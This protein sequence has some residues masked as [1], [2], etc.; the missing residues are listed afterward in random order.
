[1]RFKRGDLVGMAIAT[2]APVA[3]FLLVLAA[4]E[5]W[6]H[7]GSP[8]LAIVST[9]VAIGAG[10]IGAFS[11]FIRNWDVVGGLALLLALAVLAVVIM[12]RTGN[13]GTALAS[14][15]KLLG[16]ALFL[17]LNVAVVWQFL[18]HGLE[19]VLARRD[20]RRAA[21]ASR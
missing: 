13:D 14:G 3:M 17:G 15:V 1:M 12:Q 4:Y 18:K 9:N 19:P 7:H 11:R 20:E 6:D 16:V 2:L 10:L 5:L 8:L 21:Q